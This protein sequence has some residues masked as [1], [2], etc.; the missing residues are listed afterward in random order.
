MNILLKEYFR[1]LYS[2]FLVAIKALNCVGIGLYIQTF[3]LIFMVFFCKRKI[4]ESLIATKSNP[5]I[6]AAPPQSRLW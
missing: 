6:F 5:Y 4:I 1:K 3:S 2:Q